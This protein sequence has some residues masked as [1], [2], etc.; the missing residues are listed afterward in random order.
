MRNA[1][2][3][4]VVGLS[5]GAFFA[6]STPPKT[7]AIHRR[8]ASMAD[9]DELFADGNKDDVD[10]S[11]WVSKAQQDVIDSTMGNHEHR[12][13]HYLWHATRNSW[14]DLNANE[15]K[16]IQTLDPDWGKNAPICP[17]GDPEYKNP[18]T[19]VAGEEFLLMHHGMVAH[20][21]AMLKNAGQKCIRG[22]KEIPAKND[23]KFPVPNV[24]GDDS[25][26]DETGARLNAWATQLRNPAFLKGKSLSYLGMLIEDTIHNTMH[27]RWAPAPKTGDD[28]SP[29]DKVFT[30]KTLIAP[31]K[32]DNPGTY[33]WLGNPYS[34]H[35]NPV[36]WKLHG[37]VDDTIQ[38]WL[39]AN[40][41]QSIA[42]D[43]KGVRSCYQWKTKWVG[44]AIDDPDTAPA[45]KGPI[46]KTAMPADPA[47]MNAVLR[48]ISAKAGFGNS[49]F[50]NRSEVNAK[51]MPKA[52]AERE[53]APASNPNTDAEVFFKQFGPCSG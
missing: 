23:S 5:L 30:V 35:V 43:C 25:K 46:S 3:V 19:G 10:C 41:Y 11:D 24:A 16:T 7:E 29:T 33:H 52:G 32:F 42:S 51:S 14:A 6:C 45:P 9:Y 18:K 4:S 13:Y 47:A 36:F 40:G 37:W 50:K 17:A 38:A 27:M 28:F 12:L 22:W 34:A 48:K 31:V 39:E 21:R 49:K 20:L 53:S 26:S 15:Q 8:P 44:G 1:L 2:R